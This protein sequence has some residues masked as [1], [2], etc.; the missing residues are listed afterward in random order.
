MKAGGA[1][2]P[3]KIPGIFLPEKRMCLTEFI[4]PPFVK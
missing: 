3:I 2:T 4:R 1:V